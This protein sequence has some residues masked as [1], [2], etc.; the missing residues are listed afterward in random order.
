MCAIRHGERTTVLLIF[1]CKC[2]IFKDTSIESSYIY[3][4]VDTCTISWG[5]YSLSRRPSTPPYHDSSK[6]SHGSKRTESSARNLKS[7][8]HRLSYITYVILKPRKIVTTYT[9]TTI[10]HR[11][12]LS[13][14]LY[15]RWNHSS[16]LDVQVHKVDVKDVNRGKSPD[17]SFRERAVCRETTCNDLDVQ[18]DTTKRRSLPIT[19]DTH[20]TVARFIRTWS[21]N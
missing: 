11:I 14:Q 13:C 5:K 3:A 8:P 9:P 6:L 10:F 1:R 18:D 19:V 17:V 2:R 7:M 4:S 12:N 16:S 20:A 15:I 21:I